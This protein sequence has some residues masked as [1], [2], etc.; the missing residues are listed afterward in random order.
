MVCIGSLLHISTPTLG[1]YAGSCWLFVAFI[2]DITNDLELLNVDGAS[3]HH[4]KKVKKYFGQII[5]LHTDVKQL[6]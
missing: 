5:Q 6:G 3:S 4:H 2:E 1:F